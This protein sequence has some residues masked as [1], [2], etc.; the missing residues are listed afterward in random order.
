LGLLL[1]AL[2]TGGLVAALVIVFTRN[3]DAPTPSLRDVLAAQDPGPIHVHGLGINPADGALVIATHT[4]TYRVAPGETEAKLIGE[5][6]QDTMRFTV[7]G[8]DYF[9]GSGHPDPNDARERGTPPLLGLIES[10][11]A[12][13]S[14]RPIS[15]YGEADFH[16]L[17]F[18]GARVYAYDASHDRLLVSGDTGRTWR[19]LQRPA[20]LI[21]LAVDPRSPKRV[22]ASTEEGLFQSAS[23]G[24]KW[25]PVGL[26][27]GL[28]AW[29][30]PK[31]LFL[32]EGSG[33][34]LA[35]PGPSRRWT[36]LGDIDGRP[37]ALLA[38]SPKELYVALHDG[39]VK[40]SRDGGRSWQIRSTP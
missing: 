22:I 4:G 20:P 25:R 35:S 3:N 29:P 11:D 18:A 32:V 9:L 27:V 34:V 39:T 12:G 36:T 7:A 21:D 33:R 31:R 13:R 23:E 30:T 6:R 26:Q 38:V 16:V 14:W 17:R 2:V 19:R 1:V 37:A 10:R 15:L 40:R 24:K 28:L 8:P 5:S